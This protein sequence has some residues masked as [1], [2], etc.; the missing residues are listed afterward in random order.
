VPSFQSR[1]A[2]IVP[3]SNYRHIEAMMRSKTILDFVA[4]EDFEALAK[5]CAREAKANPKK[6]ESFAAA[7]KLR[8]EPDTE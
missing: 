3:K 1:I 5:E 2:K 7:M 6:A 4:T 8:H